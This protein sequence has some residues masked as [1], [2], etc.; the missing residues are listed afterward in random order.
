MFWHTVLLVLQGRM[1]TRPL[2]ETED[3]QER[4]VVRL[5]GSSGGQ[6]SWSK[7]VQTGPTSSAW[8]TRAWVAGCR[9]WVW[10]AKQAAALGWLVMQVVVIHHSGRWVATRGIMGTMWC[11]Q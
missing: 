7:G 4:C 6:H 9:R 1:R 2:T 5:Q 10:P 11:G 8:C 3:G